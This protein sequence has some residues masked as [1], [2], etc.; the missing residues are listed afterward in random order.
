MTVFMTLLVRDEE[1]I[2]DANL[3]YH[4]EQG[5]EH[6]I[7]TDN[8]SIDGTRDILSHYESCGVATVINETDNNYSQAKWVTRMASMA[9]AKGAHWIINNDADEFW[10]ASDGSTLK[11]WFES[12][13]IHNCVRAYRHDFICRKNGLGDFWMHMIWRKRN[14]TNPLGEPLPPKMAHKAQDG[15]S[16]SQGNHDVEGFD[17]KHIKN[18][19]LEILHFPIRSASQYL[20]KIKNGGNAYANNTELDENIGTTWRKQWAE[21]NATGELLFIKDNIKSEHELNQ[22]IDSGEVI[23]DTRLYDAMM[24]II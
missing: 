24:S 22:M 13:I 16:V 7:I 11:H 21:L 14:S 3:K 4:L 6:F 15:L 12:E 23:K 17:Y 20:R 1:D 5:I 19:G 9:Y 10:L 8:L 2:L 18:S